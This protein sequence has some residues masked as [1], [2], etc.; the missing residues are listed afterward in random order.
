MAELATALPV[1]W[2]KLNEELLALAD[3]VEDI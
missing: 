2:P 3:F 1:L